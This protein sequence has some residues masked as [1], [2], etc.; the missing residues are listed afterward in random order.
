MDRLDFSKDLPS[1]PWATRFPNMKAIYMAQD[2]NHSLLAPEFPRIDDPKYYDRE[3]VFMDKPPHNNEDVD[4]VL[5]SEQSQTKRL[6][7]MRTWQLVPFR[8]YLRFSPET[9]FI[10]G[11]HLPADPAFPFDPT[12]DPEP[13][14]LPG[15]ANSSQS[16]TASVAG[17]RSA[18]RVEYENL[19]YNVYERERIKVDE[20]SWLPFL[21]KDR[22][23]DWEEVTDSPKTAGRT[24]SVDDPKIW[25]VMRV[26]TE[27]VNRML[28]A[29]ARDRHEGGM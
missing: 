1:S 10:S 14:L 20:K 7:N 25:E 28:L 29:L 13:M 16:Q 17:L 18:R 5:W 6:G 22:W 9:G 24:W 23:F 12:L 2:K 26:V 11:G 15:Q 27:L 4:K 21:H 3:S 19:V 8:R